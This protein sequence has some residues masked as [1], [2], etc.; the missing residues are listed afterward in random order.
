MANLDL[1][2]RKVLLITVPTLN[3]SDYLSLAFLIN[4]LKSQTNKLDLLPTAE[5]PA[6]AAVLPEVNKIAEIAHKRSV[7]SFDKGSDTV[8]NIQWQQSDDKLTI[9]VSSEKG[10]FKAED[11]EFH[12][13]GADYDTIVYFG[14]NSY[15]EVEHLFAPYPELI[16]QVRHI[17]IGGKFT[18]D[19]QTVEIIVAPISGL[20]GEAIYT[21]IDVAKIT[22]ESA[23]YLLADI[24]KATTNFTSAN[25]SLLRLSADLLDKGAS[26]EEAQKILAR[27]ATN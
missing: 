21:N 14:V 11:F 15:T 19:N 26:F 23:N 4:Q 9:Y 7:I 5:L 3:F 16:Y 6:A 2:D 25:S 24:I 12:Q 22:A 20:I 1:Q 10:E 18:V 27:E 17:S 13:E 8:S